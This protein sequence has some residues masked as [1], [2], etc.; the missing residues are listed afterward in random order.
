MSYA[1]ANY[2]VMPIYLSYVYVYSV[3]QKTCSPDGLGTTV[4]EKRFILDTIVPLMRLPPIFFI[5]QSSEGCL[6]LPTRTSEKTP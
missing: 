6:S 3:L 1:S 4:S 5:S 2:L